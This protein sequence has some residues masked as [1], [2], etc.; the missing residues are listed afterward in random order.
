MLELGQNLRQ[1]RLERRQISLNH[2]PD[3]HDRLSRDET[4]KR[5]GV[6]QDTLPELPVQAAI[7]DHIH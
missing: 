2:A 3:A 1:L 5:A 7:C 6:L 4:L